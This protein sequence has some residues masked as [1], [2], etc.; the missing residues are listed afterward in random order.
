MSGTL[1]AQ[2]VNGDLQRRF[3]AEAVVALKSAA[4]AT[5]AGAAQGAV[6]KAALLYQSCEKVY[7]EEDRSEL[8]RFRPML[9]DV[10]V[11]WPNPNPKPDVLRTLLRLISKMALPV[12]FGAEV[13]TD[14]IALRFSVLV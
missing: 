10:G 2:S 4:K 9:K 5:A 14:T 1:N 7:T 11:H 6:Q 8:D 3:S 12:L 13:R